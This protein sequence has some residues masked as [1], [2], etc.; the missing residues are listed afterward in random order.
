MRRVFTLCFITA[1]AISLTVV[2]PDRHNANTKQ[3]K[4]KKDKFYHIDQFTAAHHFTPIGTLIPASGHAHLIYKINI[5]HFEVAPTKLITS[6]FNL[7][8]KHRA[9]PEEIRWAMQYTA[10]LKQ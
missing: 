8:N 10:P 2:T 1:S 5:T 4:D 3:H 9:I 7:I 6:A